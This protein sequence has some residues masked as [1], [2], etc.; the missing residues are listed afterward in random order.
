MRV[1][2]CTPVDFVADE[3]F[4]G[5]DS[6]LVCRGFQEIGIECVSVMPG[7]RRAEDPADVVRARPSELFD[8]AWWSSLGVELVLL[9][10]WG[11]PRYVEIPTAI[12]SAGIPLVQSLDTAGLTTPYGDFREWWQCLAGLWCMPQS[13][14]E[15]VRLLGKAL[16]DFIPSAFEH[17]RLAMIDVS[18]HVA[19][20]SPP[21]AASVKRYAS[22]L[23]V[24]EVAKKVIVLPHPVSSLMRAA[25]LAKEQRVIVVGRWTATDEAQ[26]DP[27]MLMQV[28]GDFLAQRP[29]W[30]AEVIGRESS[31]LA[32][33]C[34]GWDPDAVSRVSFSA[35][36]RRS[37]LTERYARSRIIFCPSRFESFHI[38]SGEALCCG[39][40]VV[41][42]DH[43]LL[44]STGW[45]TSDHSGTLAPER[46]RNALSAALLAEASL[47]DE[48]ARDPGTIATNWS[49]RLH[50]G[51]VAKSLLAQATDQP[52]V[53]PA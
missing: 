2:T 3:H 52:A 1:A 46:T 27:A 38:S 5:R 45:F 36:M 53:V 9:Y 22:A 23:G 43:P 13:M 24:P 12:R 47:W 6:G 17:R 31:A 16:R 50:A 48:G 7:D 26:K 25:P 39:C 37:E 49:H 18:D 11:D 30:Q 29:S 35:P 8:P 19:A 20:V 33:R 41:V 21:A 28:L 34:S 14:K 32:S 44:A 10:A 42:A 15:R 40:S 51:S 4:F